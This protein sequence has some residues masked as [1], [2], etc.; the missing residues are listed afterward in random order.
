MP[1]ATQSLDTMLFYRR[2][3]LDPFA[4]LARNLTA[5]FSAAGHATQIRLSGR[6]DLIMGVDDMTLA[7]GRLP[8]PL[9]TRPYGLLGVEGDEEEIRTALEEHRAALSIHLTGPAG[10]GATE[11]RWTI[12]YIATVQTFAVAPPDVIHWSP[13]ARLYGLDGFLRATGPSRTSAAKSPAQPRKRTRMPERQVAV[14]AM[15]GQAGG[16]ASPGME[17]AV[18]AIP[19]AAGQLKE[20]VLALLDSH[21]RFDGT[22]ACGR[23]DPRQDRARD[24]PGLR[25][26]KL[27]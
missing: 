22:K 3:P 13:L 24:L 17:A 25:L 11:R 9:D 15:G 2:P 12:G 21:G 10:D 5:A 27:H 8:G 14:G 4:V 6:N 20:R 18:H 19:D 7:L 26:R 23:L 1:L 16:Q